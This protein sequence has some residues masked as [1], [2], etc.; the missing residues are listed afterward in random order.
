MQFKGSYVI[1]Y[2][3]FDYFAWKSAKLPKEKSP[4]FKM[5]KLDKNYHI[6]LVKTIAC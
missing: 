2:Y 1:Y 4:K 3:I 5:E 6:N